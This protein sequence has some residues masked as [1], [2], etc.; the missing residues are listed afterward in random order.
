MRR[1]LFALSVIFLTMTAHAAGDAPVQ[2]S[3]SAPVTAQ[4]SVQK[5]SVTLYGLYGYN[6]TYSHTGGFDLVGFMPIHKYFELD[7][8]LEYQSPQTC[9]VS[10]FARPK[11][12]LPVGELFLDGAINFRYYGDASMGIFTTSASFGYRM[13]YVSVQIGISSRLLI[14]MLRQSGSDSGNVSEPVNMTYRIAFNVRPSTSLWNIGFG[15]SNYT[16]YEFERAWQC[17]FFLSG[18]YDFMPHLTALLEADL[19]PTGIFH[20]NARFWGV[21]VRAGIKYSF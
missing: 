20:M 15:M 14:D 18:H 4:A 8:A 13:D 19:K 5:Y 2:P 1:L 9:A 12:P 10:A 11:F 21:N 6:E 3:A 16:L 7:A 17:I